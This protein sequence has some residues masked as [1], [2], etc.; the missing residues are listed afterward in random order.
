[1]RRLAR[2]PGMVACS[3][4]TLAIAIA[5]ITPLIL[6][7]TIGVENAHRRGFLIRTS[8]MVDH[9]GRYVPFSIEGAW[10]TL[11]LCGLWRPERHWI[12]RLGTILGVAW[13]TGQVVEKSIHVFVALFS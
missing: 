2:Q 1:M 8:Q 12:D 11:A 6:G 9:Y 4:A 13:I 3:S 5:L 7:A 10:V